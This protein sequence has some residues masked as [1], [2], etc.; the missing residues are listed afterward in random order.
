M[1]MR[2]LSEADVE[3]LIDPPMAIASAAEAYRLHAAG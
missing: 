1:L 2:L 3:R